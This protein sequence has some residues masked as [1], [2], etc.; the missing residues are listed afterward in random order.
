MSS[1]TSRTGFTVSTNLKTELVLKSAYPVLAASHLVYDGA[2][3]DLHLLLIDLPNNIFKTVNFIGN[4]AS[5][6]DVSGDDPVLV[7]SWVE[8]EL[9]DLLG[10]W[11]GLEGIVCTFNVDMWNCVITHNGIQYTG[12]DTS[13]PD[14]MAKAFIKVLKAT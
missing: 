6:D 12:N 3:N 11:P 5:P 7:R 13:K 14:S 9:N 1:R 8:R 4:V 2:A 10:P